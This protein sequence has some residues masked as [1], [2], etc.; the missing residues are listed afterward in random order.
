MQP[1]YLVVQRKDG[2]LRWRLGQRVWSA[3]LHLIA[4]DSRVWSLKREWQSRLGWR[5]EA[6][7][8]HR[9][10]VDKRLGALFA[11]SGFDVSGGDRRRADC[12]HVG[13]RKRR[14]TTE[15][16]GIDWWLKMRLLMGNGELRRMKTACD[17]LTRDDHMRSW[18]RLGDVARQAVDIVS[19]DIGQTVT[20]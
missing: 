3:D 12:G 17:T 11:G 16:E 4:R 13:V 15:R 2:E 19:L 14:M 20:G 6:D 9:M 1:A 7:R 5:L 18:H 8:R 10:Y